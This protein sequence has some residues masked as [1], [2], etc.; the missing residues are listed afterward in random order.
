MKN[1]L[2]LAV[3]AV[4]TMSGFHQAQASTLL[5]DTGVPTGTGFPVSLNSGQWLASEFSTP[6]EVSVTSIEAY[7]L[8]DN[9]NP[10]SATFTI[11]VYQNAANNTPDTVDPAVFSQQ[12]TYTADG[13]NGLSG[14]NVDLPAGSYWVAFEVG[15]NGDTLQG[16]LP[17]PSSNPLTTAFYDGTST[18]GYTVLSGSNY[19]FGVQIAAVPVPP[20]VLLFASGLLAAGRLGKRRAV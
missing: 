8:A 11:T 1:L 15:P 13:W 3:V 10:D 18:G 16:L 12:A 2:S 20:S 5:V 4:L 19:S 7:I 6:G 9:G 17:V 14:I